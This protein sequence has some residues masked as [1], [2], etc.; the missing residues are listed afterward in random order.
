VRAASRELGV[1][2]DDARRALKVASLT[3]EAKEA[4]REVGLDDNRT[5]LLKAAEQPLERQAATIREIAEA[6]EEAKH[7]PRSERPKPATSVP[8][9]KLIDMTSEFSD[10]DPDYHLNLMIYAW[11]ACTEED[12][13]RFLRFIPARYLG[14]D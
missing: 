11:E 8:L 4:A 2:R 6:K 13:Q 5:A 12:R 1:D 9:Q 3:E 7:T 14:K 10:V